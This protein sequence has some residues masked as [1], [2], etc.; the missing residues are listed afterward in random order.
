MCLEKSQRDYAKTFIE[1]HYNLTEE[2]LIVVVDVDEIFTREGIQYIKENPPKNYYF[3]KGSI[4]FPYY[5]HKVRDCDKSIVI[6]YNKNMKTLSNY[7]NKKTVDNNTLK[8]KSN[9]SKP[10][11]THCSY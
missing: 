5:Y 10:F 7:K 4:Y 9:P 1:E 3:V 6:R 2:D 8:Y 11:I